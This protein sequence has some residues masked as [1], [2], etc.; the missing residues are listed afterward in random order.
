L[1]VPP[2]ALRSTIYDEGRGGR[3]QGE[4]RKWFPQTGSC[5]AAKPAAPNEKEGGSLRRKWGGKWAAKGAP[6]SSPMAEMG[7]EGKFG[8]G[9]GQEQLMRPTA[10]HEKSGT[11]GTCGLLTIRS[12]S[13]RR[14]DGHVRREGRGLS[15]KGSGERWFVPP[16]SSFVF[17]NLPSC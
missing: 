1:E 4:D 15:G 11:C 9:E 2:G 7:D 12:P 3:S 8:G 16:R 6:C 5:R 14:T 10:L 17:L 13:R